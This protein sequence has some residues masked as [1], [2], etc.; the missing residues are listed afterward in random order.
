[1][2]WLTGAACLVI[3]LGTFIGAMRSLARAGFPPERSG[4]A[5]FMLRMGVGASALFA[6]VILL[7]MAPIALL[8]PCPL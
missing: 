8:T 7:S 6:L 2:L 4:I 5:P 1:M 3:A